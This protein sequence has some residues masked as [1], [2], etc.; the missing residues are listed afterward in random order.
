MKENKTNPDNWTQEE[1]DRVVGLFKL[2]MEIDQRNN[3]EM[4]KSR[5]SK[6]PHIVLDKDGNKITL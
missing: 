1:N 4:Y 3:P 5:N 2:L 6:E